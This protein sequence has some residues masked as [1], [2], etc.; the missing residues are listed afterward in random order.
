MRFLW[1]PKVFLT[2][3]HTPY[4]IYFKRNYKLL[5]YIYFWQT[6]IA[7]WVTIFWI[8]FFLSGYFVW[9]KNWHQFITSILLNDWC[10]RILYYFT[11]RNALGLRDGSIYSVLSLSWTS[12][13]IWTP[14][15]CVKIPIWVSQKL[16]I[17]NITCFFSWPRPE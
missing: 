1:N 17:I 9:L 15:V 8:F 12:L 4:F 7:K 6:Y 13:L 5:H 16:V 3:Y 2:K 11:I 10:R 14:F